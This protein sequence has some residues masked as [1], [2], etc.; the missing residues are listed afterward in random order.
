MQLESAEILIVGAGPAGSVAAALLRKQGR[1]VLV[2]ERE[3]FPRFSIGESLLPQSM[4][5]LEEAGMLRAVVEAGFQ[6]KNGAAF[7]KNGVYTDFDFRDKHSE[8]WGTTYQ[9]QR[10]D[11]DH[12]LAKEAEKQGAEI[13]FRHEVL[14][15]A[16][17]QP[18]GRSLV[19]VK[20]PDGEQYQVDA[21][22]ILDASGFG[23]ILPRLLKLETPSNFPVRGAIF[24]HVADGIG[25]RAGFDRNKIRVTVHPKHCNVW[26]WTIPFAGG[27]CSLGVVAETA[28]LEQYKGSP[29]ERLQMIVAEEPSLAELLKDATWDTPARQIVGYSANVDK[30]WGE[31]YALLGNAGEFLDPVFSSGVTIAVRSASLAAAALK[32]QFAGEA[33]DWQADYGTPLRR[34][35]DTFRAFVESWYRGGFQTIIF[36]DRQQPE[37]RRM[38]SA[39]LAGYA[40]DLTNPYVKETARRLA[41]LEATCELT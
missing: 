22:F 16:L 25:P 23:R 26:F 38:I 29:T 1:Q 32:R 2:I 13:R 21:G 31:G 18:G 20:R 10:A 19:T 39:I 33:V 7:M 5:Y 8:G 3:A 28:F 30:L 11:F 14:D 12:L 36:H 6:Y 40:W 4:Q 24:T 35:V 17:G 34:G 41:A 15:I 37:I 27:R 9:V